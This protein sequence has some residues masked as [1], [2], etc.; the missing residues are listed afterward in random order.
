L[1]KH[2]SGSAVPRVVLRGF[3]PAKILQGIRSPGE[4]DDISRIGSDR[5]DLISGE[6]PKS[7]SEIKRNDSG[8][9]ERIRINIEPGDD[10]RPSVDDGMIMTVKLNLTEGMTT[11]LKD[12]KLVIKTANQDER[13]TY[14]GAARFPS[15]VTSF[16]EDWVV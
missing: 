16:D 13:G 15:E 9:V 3:L 5:I 6:S 10:S 8:H 1:S 11:P 2:Y 4:S 12:R 14:P 7:G